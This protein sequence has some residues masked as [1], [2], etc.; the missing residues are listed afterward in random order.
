MESRRQGA[1]KERM[2]DSQFSNIKGKPE[3]RSTLGLISAHGLLKLY[4]IKMH[5]NGL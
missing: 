5:E 3:S 2:I 4:H 1:A